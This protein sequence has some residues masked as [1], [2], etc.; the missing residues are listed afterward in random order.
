MLR[1]YERYVPGSKLDLL[2]ELCSKLNDAL[3]TAVSKINQ[4]MLTI[5]ACNTRDHFDFMGNLS[6]KGREEYWYEM[7]ELL[8]QFDCGKIKLLPTPQHPHRG[9]SSKKTWDRK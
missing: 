9:H 1:H 8:D 7:N 3:N 2:F 6:A 5:T 4:K